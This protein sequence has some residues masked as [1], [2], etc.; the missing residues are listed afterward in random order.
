MVSAGY[1]FGRKDV[2]VDSRTSDAGETDSSTTKLPKRTV[3]TTGSPVFDEAFTSPGGI[4][5]VGSAYLLGS[6]E[7]YKT[8]PAADLKFEI[9]NWTT[10]ETE[11]ISVPSLG[12]KWYGLGFNYS[13]YSTHYTYVSDR[14]KELLVFSDQDDIGYHE[15]MGPVDAGIYYWNRVYVYDIKARKVSLIYSEISQGEI[16][17][18]TDNFDD[19][20]HAESLE[21]LGVSGS[22]LV[23]N[24]K[25]G[26]SPGPCSFFVIRGHSG[27]NLRYLDLSNPSLGL[28]P[29]T[30]S[31]EQHRNGVYQNE[32]CG[33]GL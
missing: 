16:P 33:E 20:I 29:Y 4:V 18:E 12:E 28:Q 26:G 23:I 24:L 17:S 27:L 15:N 2:A 6:Y 19:W 8:N 22:Q 9:T 31:D 14:G 11:T 13:P 5:N 1:Y 3:L 30:V 10:L 25:R 21:I 7:S 32:R